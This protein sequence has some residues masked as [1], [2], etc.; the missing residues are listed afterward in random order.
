MLLVTQDRPFDVV[1]HA[2][3][4][5]FSCSTVDSVDE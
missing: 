1:R 4:E 5:A 2:A 3:K